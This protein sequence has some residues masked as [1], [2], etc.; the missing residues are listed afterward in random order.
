MAIGAQA[1][2]TTFALT[3]QPIALPGGK[4]TVAGTL[5][6]M[7]LT[8]TDKF[9]LRND[10]IIAP[11]NNFQ[12]FFGGFNYRLPIISHK[13]NNASPTLNGERFQFYLTASVGIDR[14]TPAVKTDATKSHY[15]VLAGGGVNYDLTGSGHWTFGAEVRYAKLPGLQNNTAIVSVGPTLHF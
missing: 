15:A 13:L 4:Q 14:I 3:A 1:Q 10:N 12:G 6:G 2:S 9:D 8:V 11:G 7:A 5:A